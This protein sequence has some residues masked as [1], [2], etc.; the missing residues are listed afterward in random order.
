LALLKEK[1][2]ANAALGIA[3]FPIDR[4]V[5]LMLITPDEVSERRHSFGGHPGLLPRWA[6]NLALNLL[7]R[8]AEGD[9]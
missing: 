6:V 1:Y 2:G 5:D 9:D 8:T 3:G 7:R 4:A